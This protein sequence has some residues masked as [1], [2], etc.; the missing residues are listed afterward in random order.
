VL[1]R[2]LSLRTRLALVFFA[3]TLLSVAAVYLYVAPGLQSR[4]MGEK[5]TDLAHTARVHS[6]ALRRTVGSSVSLPEVRR[7]VS[8]TA[9][10]TGDRVTLLSVN[11][12]DGQPQLVRLADSGNS[13]ASGPV[14]L[15]IARRA[16]RT[17]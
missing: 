15:S 8:R 16:V 13:A 10:L 4:L 1:P 12:A 3:I 7:L 14:R 17:R 6:A 2:T 9:N 5:Q 11:Q